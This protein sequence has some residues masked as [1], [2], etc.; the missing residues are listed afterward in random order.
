MAATPIR[1]RRRSGGC[2][3]VLIVLVVNAQ[4]TEEVLFGA[5]GAA[6]AMRPGSVVVGSATTSP[7]FVVQLAKRL[8]MHSMLLLDAPVTGGVTGAAG[9][10][11][12]PAQ[13]RPRGCL[14]RLR[15]R[16]CRDL[17]TR[18]PLR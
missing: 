12:D 14:L 11:T 3:D 7:S 1:A 4:Q 10:N 6:A 16:A 13:F 17:R 8:D 15:R 18:I 5:Q 9:R 2:C